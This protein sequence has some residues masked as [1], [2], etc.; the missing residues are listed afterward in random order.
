MPIISMFFGI[1]VRMYFFDDKQH[2]TPHIHVE[3]QG[4]TAVVEIP[5]G[6]VLE[7]TIRQNKM[8][9][10]QAWIEIHQEELIADWSLATNGEALQK[11]DPLK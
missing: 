3:Y 10:I 4:E 1:I 6:T 8:K 7:G 2:H 5:S 11:I 9:L